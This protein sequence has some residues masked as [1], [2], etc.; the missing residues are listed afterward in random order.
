MAD[1]QI[2]ELLE[3]ARRYDAT[4]IAHCSCGRSGAIDLD[5]AILRA[6]TSRIRQI[7]RWARCSRCGGRYPRIELVMP[8]GSRRTYATG[9]NDMG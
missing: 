3:E 7:G 8:G 6:G 2:I 1:I 5:R 9:Y 4:L